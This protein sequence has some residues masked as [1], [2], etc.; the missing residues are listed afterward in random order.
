ML[1]RQRH[2]RVDAR[3][4]ILHVDGVHDRSSGNVLECRRDHI[5]LG[6]VDHQRRLDAHRQQ[7]HHLGHL[8]GLVG[9]FG[10]SNADVE[11]VRA[12]VHLLAR[13]LENPLVV[14]GEE[15]SL[16]FARPLRVHALA[17]EKRWR[18]LPEV[19]RAHGR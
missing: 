6:G 14:V 15:Q 5:R 11:H 13:H 17:D 4:A 10:G 3:A 16:H 2:D 7:L 8:P 19:G 9:A 1:L 18:V 12:G